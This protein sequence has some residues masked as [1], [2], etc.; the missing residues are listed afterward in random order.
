MSNQ[1]KTP[2]N[3]IEIDLTPSQGAELFDQVFSKL[4]IEFAERELFKGKDQ[5]PFAVRNGDWVLAGL[6]SAKIAFGEGADDYPLPSEEIYS[7][8]HFK[9]SQLIYSPKEN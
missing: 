8:K 4:D 6:V 5:V 1:Q 3:D 2:I 9:A 7:S